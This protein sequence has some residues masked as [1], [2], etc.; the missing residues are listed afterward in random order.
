[1]IAF[2]GL[3]TKIGDLFILLHK[4]LKNRIETLFKVVIN[5]LRKL[6]QDPD[7]ISIVQKKF[8]LADKLK[9]MPQIKNLADPLFQATRD[10]ME[11]VVRDNKLAIE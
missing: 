10:R 3:K 9:N 8:D 6:I 5:G 4:D 11:K 2:K 7:Q 1:M